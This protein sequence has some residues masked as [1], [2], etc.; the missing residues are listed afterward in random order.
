MGTKRII[1]IHFIEIKIG[2]IINVFLLY[3]F[4]KFTLFFFNQTFL[5][6]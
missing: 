1:L 4:L 6:Q 3:L 2:N 5:N